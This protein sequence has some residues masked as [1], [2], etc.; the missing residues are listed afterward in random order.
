MTARPF[1]PAL[2]RLEAREV[3]AA[4]AFSNGTLT[5]NLAEVTG[6]SVA[7]DAATPDLVLINGRASGGAANFVE[8]AVGGRL[9]A[10]AVRQIVVNGS[11]QND[12]INLAGVDARGFTRLT[13]QAVIYG[14]G[15]NDTINGTAGND[16]IYAG[17]G[18]DRVFGLGGAD[19]IWGQ[20]GNDHL[21]G[22]GNSGERNTDGDDRIDGGSGNDQ[23]YGWGGNDLMV[24]RSGDDFFSGGGGYDVAYTDSADYQPRYGFPGV[25]DTRWGTP[26][27]I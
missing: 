7:L 23:L 12:V 10:D 15:G 16:E 27:N 6:R 24:G 19:R 8:G 2:D 25:E 20:G 13:G 22:D 3:P 21:Y 14:G 18:H 5:V 9:R 26:P 17:G 11:D 1:R 4:Y